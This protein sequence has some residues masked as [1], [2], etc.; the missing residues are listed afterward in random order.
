MDILLT[1]DEDHHSRL[2]WKQLNPDTRISWR[3]YWLNAQLKKVVEYIDERASCNQ[4]GF[5]VTNIDYMEW[6]GIKEIAGV[7]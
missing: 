6:Q 2:E 5:L 1:M 4:F 3:E 7:K